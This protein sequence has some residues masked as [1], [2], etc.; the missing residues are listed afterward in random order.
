VSG[1]RQ[2]ILQALVNPNTPG[3]GDTEASY[4]LQPV[5]PFSLGENWKVITYTIMP[6]IQL[7]GANGTDDVTGLGDTLINLY[8]SPKKAGSLVWGL[9]PAILVPTRTHPELGSDRWALGPSGILFYEKGNWSAGVVLQNIWSL[10]GSGVSRVNEF[11]AQYVYN[12][13]LPKGWFFYS[14]A[15]I[16]ADWR[17]DTDDRWTV[18]VGGGFGRVFKIAKQ[19]VSL[20]AQAF[21]NV[22]TPSDGP[23]L[24]WI[25]QFSLLFPQ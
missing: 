12:Y 24:T 7:P 2:V 14:N 11:A 9:G 3:S 1:L 13:N 15:T 6:I 5:F 17:V 8:V 18:P 10:G 25:V 19:P 20:S 22:V 4:S 23:H 21:Y 16:T